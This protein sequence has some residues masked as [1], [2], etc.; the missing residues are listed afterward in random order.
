MCQ[1]SGECHQDI[2][3]GIRNY[4]RKPEVRTVA[5]TISQVDRKKMEEECTCWSKE[6]RHRIRTSHPPSCLIGVLWILI[7]FLIDHRISPE[8]FQGWGRFL[9]ITMTDFVSGFCIVPNSCQ[10]HWILY[11]SKMI[12][13]SSCHFLQFIWE[14]LGWK[15]VVQLH[16][17]NTN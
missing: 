5:C 14:L 15:P 9:S 13:S 2:M 16:L 7:W 1:W 6:A 8:V 12:R 10:P 11:I 17:H 4:S 3:L